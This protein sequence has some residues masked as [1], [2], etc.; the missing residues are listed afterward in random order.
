M[1]AGNAWQAAIAKIAHSQ[2][3]FLSNRMETL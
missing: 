1:G 3:N 2:V